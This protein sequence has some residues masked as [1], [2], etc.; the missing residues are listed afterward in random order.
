MD[1]KVML[2][3]IDFYIKIRKHMVVFYHN[4][5]ITDKS[6]DQKL[7]Y[8]LG[9]KMMDTFMLI[10][11]L[12]YD[13]SLLKSQELNLWLK[14]NYPE[15]NGGVSYML[16]NFSSKLYYFIF[17]YVYTTLASIKHTVF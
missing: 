1:P 6:L 17:H 3:N 13:E 11:K 12:S 15:M 7:H 14:D 2:R 5:L 4:H 10:S 8:I 16:Y 9:K